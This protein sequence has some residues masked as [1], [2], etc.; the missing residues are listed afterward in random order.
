MITEEQQRLIDE[1]KDKIKQEE[2]SMQ[3]SKQ[4]S[5]SLTEQKIDNHINNLFDK[6][7]EKHQQDIDNLADDAVKQEIDIKQNQIKGRAKI[8]KSRTNQDVTEEK[9]RED[10]K[11][12]ER[13]KTVLKG[14]GLVTQLPAP[15]RIT[16]LI[17]GYPFYFIYLC[18][19]GALTLFL[20]FVAKGFITMVADCCDRFAEVN[21]K[22]I[23]NNNN[24]DFSLGKAIFNT[25]KWLLVLAVVLTII[26]LLIVR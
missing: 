26:I 10:E 23:Q 2:N 8:I 12:H 25:L 19:V 5:N 20:T 11:K 24:K 13:A 9:T 6:A 21:A 18:S 4:K 22:Y 17:V 1:E 15:Y 16:A 14:F 3:L 7:L